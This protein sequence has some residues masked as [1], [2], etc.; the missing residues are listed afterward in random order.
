MLRRELISS[1]GDVYRFFAP[2]LSMCLLD[3]SLLNEFFF[4]HCLHVFCLGIEH[5]IAT[6]CASNKCNLIMWRFYL[7]RMLF[8]PPHVQLFC[9]FSLILL[10]YLFLI[11][12]FAVLASFVIYI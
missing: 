5:L 9:P 2:L 10:N 1:C 6:D 4:V 8:L 7:V 12:F 3:F 11:I